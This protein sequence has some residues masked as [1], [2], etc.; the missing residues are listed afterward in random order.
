MTV[1]AGLKN[2]NP[3]S[4]ETAHLVYMYT[5][6]F[7]LARPRSAEYT[8]GICFETAKNTKP[9]EFFFIGFQHAL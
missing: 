2:E 3:E 4:H 1:H 8:I 9:F 6:I 5:V 7:V